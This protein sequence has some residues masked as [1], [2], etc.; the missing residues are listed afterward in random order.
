MQSVEDDSSSRTFQPQELPSTTVRCHEGCP[1]YTGFGP[2]DV[3]LGTCPATVYL[4]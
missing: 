2:C 1:P 3:A 4:A